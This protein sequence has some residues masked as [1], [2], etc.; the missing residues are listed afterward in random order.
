MVT[1]SSLV[2][3]SEKEKAIGKRELVRLVCDI[4]RGL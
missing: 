3:R 4:Q 2:I 1:G